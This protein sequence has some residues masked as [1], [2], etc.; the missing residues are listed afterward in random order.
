M[1]KGSIQ[2]LRVAG[3]SQMAY[4]QDC[5]KPISR[6]ALSRKHGTE[7]VQ[8]DLLEPYTDFI[9]YNI[10]IDKPMAMHRN[11]F[12]I[13]D[14]CITESAK[15]LVSVQADDNNYPG[16]TALTVPC[17][18]LAAPT[19]INTVPGNAYL[20]TGVRTWR[21]DCV[22]GAQVCRKDHAPSLDFPHGGRVPIYV[23]NPA[24]R[25]QIENFGSSIQNRV[26]IK[27]DCFGPRSPAGEYH[28]VGTVDYRQGTSFR[29]AAY[30]TGTF[31]EDFLFQ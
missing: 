15:A 5:Y 12:V 13:V 23:A 3:V 22:G 18:R 30:P 16:V 7:I 11:M 2:D 31:A 21:T 25:K 4:D 14:P 19:E 27:T 24:Q 1:I 8:G 29:L 9:M 20:S 17:F 28:T 26:L 10:P 6:A